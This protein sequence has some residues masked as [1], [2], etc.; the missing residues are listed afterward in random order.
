MLELHLAN[1]EQFLQSGANQS[2]TYSLSN[3]R[4]LCDVFTLNSELTNTY[5]S[6]VLSG[7]PLVFPL[8]SLV[9]TS[10]QLQAGTPSFDAN[11]ARSSPRAN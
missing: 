9:V 1:G 4:V 5:A 11:V 6:H 7:R 10:F 8:K 3:V 2:T